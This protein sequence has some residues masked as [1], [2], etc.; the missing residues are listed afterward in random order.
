MCNCIADIDKR[1]EPDGQCINASIF[2]NPRRAA[3]DLI[4]MDKW[5]P[6]NRRKK[7][8]LMIASFCPFCGEKYADPPAATMEELFG[9]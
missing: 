5:V 1:L 4:R 9:A 3:I 6:E 8:R 7:P 2:G